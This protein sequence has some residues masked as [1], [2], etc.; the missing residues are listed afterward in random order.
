MLKVYRE[1]LQRLLVDAFYARMIASPGGGATNHSNIREV[2]RRSLRAGYRIP[3]NNTSQLTT[4][5]DHM[6]YA[7]NPYGIYDKEDIAVTHTMNILAD[8]PDEKGEVELLDTIIHI[9]GIPWTRTLSGNTLRALREAIL[10]PSERVKLSASLRAKENLC[11]N[12]HRE[13]ADGELITLVKSGNE[14]QIFCVNCVSPTKVACHCSKHAQD[15]GEKL[16]RAIGRA[17]AKCQAG[18]ESE[19]TPIFQ[20][21]P[22]PTPVPPPPTYRAYDSGATIG[23]ATP[24]PGPGTATRGGR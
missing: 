21:N 14:P 22:A 4:A 2:V 17:G 18:K 12:C 6:G 24:I 9:L 19:E 1:L 13:L 7:E 23:M 3:G 5:V 8:P 16:N 11:G 15:L 20:S 10:I